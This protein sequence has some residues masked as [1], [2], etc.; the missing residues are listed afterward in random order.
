MRFWDSSA[1][2]PLLVEEPAS[3]RCRG[4][5]RADSRIIV[6]LLTRTECVSAIRR[7][8]RDGEL[9]EPDAAQAGQRLEKLARRW[10]EIDAALPVREA[11]ERLLRVHALRAADAMQLAAA[12]VAASGRPQGKPLVALDDGLATAA[13][14]EGFDVIKPDQHA[15]R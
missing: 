5:L 3:A 13:G 8:V 9:A 11:A 6:W 4:L 1:I 7:Q 12:L 2:V 15:G 10:S 14:R